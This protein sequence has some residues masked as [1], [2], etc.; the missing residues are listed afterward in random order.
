MYP[1]PMWAG[2]P[3][4]HPPGGRI[5]GNWFSTISQMSTQCDDDDGENSNADDNDD[6]GDGDGDN[7]KTKLST[8]PVRLIEV[9]VYFSVQLHI[10]ALSKFCTQKCSQQKNYLQGFPKTAR[11]LLFRH[12]I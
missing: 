2:V 4:P 3:Q 6:D 11:Y 9:V 10:G 7:D 12:H 5:D 8:T 1:H